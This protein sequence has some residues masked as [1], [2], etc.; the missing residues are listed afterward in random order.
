[1]SPVRFHPGS[2]GPQS[3]QSVP[4]EHQEYSAPGPPSSQ[5]PLDS[6]EEYPQVLA[7]LGFP[8]WLPLLLQTTAPS[9]FTRRLLYWKSAPYIRYEKLRWPTSPKLTQ[10]EPLYVSEK[11]PPDTPRAFA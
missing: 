10:P 6:S 8:P 11:R 2:R 9:A 3:A 4:K 1:M 5:T 7:Q